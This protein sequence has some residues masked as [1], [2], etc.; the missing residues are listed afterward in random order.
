VRGPVGSGVGVTTWAYDD[1]HRPV[2]VSDPFGGTVG[3]AY[4]A[5]GNRSQLSYPDGKSV[6]Y[7]YDP[8]PIPASTISATLNVF[9]LA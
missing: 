4:D 7:A 3:Y 1:L 6:G 2:A 8:T 9:E 5:V